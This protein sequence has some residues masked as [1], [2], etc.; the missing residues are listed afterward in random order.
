MRGRPEAVAEQV[1]V[2]AAALPV[3]VLRAAH[4][5]SSDSLPA[6]R[7]ADV[8]KKGA[9]QIEVR[10]ATKGADQIQGPSSCPSLHPSSARLHLRTAVSSTTSAGM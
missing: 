9:S 7:Q 2:Q 6:S 4:L 1:R 10:A 3:P 8:F 5:R